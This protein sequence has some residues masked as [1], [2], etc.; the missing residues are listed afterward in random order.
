[1]PAQK[2][3]STKKW[4]NKILASLP[5]RDDEE[6]LTGPLRQ[7]FTKTGTTRAKLLTEVMQAEDKWLK[8][9]VEAFKLDY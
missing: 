8:A 3:P 2:L 6:G 5:A 1:M 9:Q 7:A 4:Q